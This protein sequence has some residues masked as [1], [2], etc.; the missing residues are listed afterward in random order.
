MGFWLWLCYL[1][2]STSSPLL[3]SPPPLEEAKE[4]SIR[5]FSPLGNSPTL[6]RE[7]LNSS[8]LCVSSC[9]GAFLRSCSSWPRGVHTNYC[10]ADNSREP[11]CTFLELYLYSF[12]SSLLLSTMPCKF[13]PPWSLLS[14]IFVSSP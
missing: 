3:P 1:S 10:S 7:N 5:T 14:P 2:F 12:H 6:A 13:Q 9:N 11:L 4:L 8:Q